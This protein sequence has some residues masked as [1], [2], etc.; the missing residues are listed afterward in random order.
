LTEGGGG[1]EGAAASE[2]PATSRMPTDQES[3]G[4]IKVTTIRLVEFLPY[5]VE[6]G[7]WL[8]YMDVGFWESIVLIDIILCLKYW[9]GT[10]YCS[11]Y[12]S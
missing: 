7:V 2:P 12:T 9:N 11:I 8:L 3:S 10:G 6:L 4:V 1:S 5:I